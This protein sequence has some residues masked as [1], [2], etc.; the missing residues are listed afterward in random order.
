VSF[1]DENRKH[2]C[3]TEKISG[4]PKAQPF[5]DPVKPHPMCNTLVGFK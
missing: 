1:R 3:K 2:S 5:F 4:T